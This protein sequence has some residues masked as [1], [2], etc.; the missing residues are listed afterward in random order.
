MWRSS[1]RSGVVQ[2]NTQVYGEYVLMFVS[3][4]AFGSVLQAIFG[5]LKLLERVFFKSNM[6]IDQPQH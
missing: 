4:A 2:V 1:R 3:D 5:L 6:Y